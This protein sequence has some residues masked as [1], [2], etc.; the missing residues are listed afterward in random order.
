MLECETPVQIFDLLWKVSIPPRLKC[1]YYLTKR[2]AISRRIRL[3][4]H[5]PSLKASL[6]KDLQWASQARGVTSQARC[7]VVL[8]QPG[9]ACFSDGMGMKSLPS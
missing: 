5:V 7:T 1:G 3:I 8:E 4:R 2:R 9:L 6:Q